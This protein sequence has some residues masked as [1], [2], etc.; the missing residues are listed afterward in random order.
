MSERLI[1]AVQNSKGNSVNSGSNKG[2]MSHA[3]SKAN[4][5]EGEEV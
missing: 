3:P 1:R 4:M 2:A 5:A